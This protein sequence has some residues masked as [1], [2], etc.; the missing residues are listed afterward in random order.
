[1]ASF[2]PRN[3]SPQIVGLSNKLDRERRGGTPSKGA[4]GEVVGAAVVDGKL[5]GKV[6]Q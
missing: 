2:A 3:L 6:V 4:H 5:F 1:M